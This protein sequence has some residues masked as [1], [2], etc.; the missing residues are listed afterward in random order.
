[1]VILISGTA[2]LILIALFMFFAGRLLRKPGDLLSKRGLSL[3]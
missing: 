1:M 2:T 3:I